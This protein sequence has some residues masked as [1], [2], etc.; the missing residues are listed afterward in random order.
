MRHD[1]I[2]DIKIDDIK[3]IHLENEMNTNLNY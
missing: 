3:F 2:F 1:K